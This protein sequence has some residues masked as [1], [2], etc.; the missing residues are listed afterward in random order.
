[1]NFLAKA[2]SLKP[3]LED[4]ES[5]Y[6]EVAPGFTAYRQ[7]IEAPEI[8]VK[9]E[10]PIDVHALNL[11]DEPDYCEEFGFCGMVMP[12][13]EKHFGKIYFGGELRVYDGLT[14]LRTKMIIIT[15]NYL[16]RIWGMSILE[17]VAALRSWGA[18]ATWRRWCAVAVKKA[19]KFGVFQSEPIRHQL[20]YWPAIYR[21]EPQNNAIQPTLVP[22]AAGGMR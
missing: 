12:M 9:S 14:F 15:S 5:S 19:A 20:I 17:G 22:R 11:L 13:A 1:M 21:S 4:V 6:A 8:S 7:E 16:L 18:R 3:T 2:T 10:T